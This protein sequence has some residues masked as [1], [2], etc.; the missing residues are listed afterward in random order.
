MFQRPVTSRR[1]PRVGEILI[2]LHAHIHVITITN[3]KHIEKTPLIGLLPFS[4]PVTGFRF[5]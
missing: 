1:S 2:L 5:I 4:I 3:T